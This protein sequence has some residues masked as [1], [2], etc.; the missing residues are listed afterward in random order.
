MPSARWN[1]I[2]HG[3]AQNAQVPQLFSQQ[4]RRTPDALCLSSETTSLTYYQLEKWTNGLATDLQSLGVGPETL[5][6]I[7][8]PRSP[9]TIVAALAVMKAGG[10]Y[11]PLDS[12]YPVARLHS[13]LQDVPIRV[14]IT[15]RQVGSTL[16]SGDW[17]VLFLEG[18]PTDLQRAGQPFEPVAVRSE[19]LAYA[20]YTSGSTGRPKAVQITHGGLL[21][22]V[23]WHQ[24]NFSVTPSDRASQVASFGFD[25]AAWEVWPYL[26]AGASVHFPDDSTRG[27][28]RALCEWLQKRRVTVS[29]V[30]TALAESM[31]ELDWPPTIALRLLLTGGDAL[32]KYP[33][34]NLP[35]RLVNNYGPTECTV[36][37]TSGVISSDDRQD[38][39][40]TIGRPIDNVQTYIC[41]DQLEQVPVGM[42]GELY[43]GG[44]GV[45]RGYLNNPKLNEESFVPNPF[46]NLHGDRLYKTG[47][48][49]RYLPNGEIAF[50][51]R[52]DEQIKIRGYRIEPNEIVSILNQCPGVQSS[53]VVAAG[54]PHGDKRL[55]AYLVAFEGQVTRSLLQDYLRTYLPDYMVPTTFVRLDSFPLKPT[56]KLDGFALPVP[57]P[58]NTIGDNIYVA[59]R[60]QVEQRMVSILAE[61]LGME[62][63]GVNDN[64][65]F[66][67]GHSLLGTQLIARARDS[68]GVELPLRKVFDC[69]TA[70]E[71]AAEIEQMLVANRIS[72]D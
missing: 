36:V 32:R 56:G 8:L 13:M 29:F 52:R 69:P 7:C 46:S 15:Q 49:V 28:G 5:V 64:F 20:I 57:T 39:Q 53:M 66:L 12:E 43:I 17:Q 60:N 44:A 23:R 59:P 31:I 6:A 70:A 58:L 61:L 48:L 54:D 11:V 25:A 18:E 41:N 71:L 37:T 24:R 22:L 51:G 4:A 10:A 38:R 62:K 40:P 65:F 34:A 42:V 1:D 47:D 26:C 63:V 30:P 67:G 45:S 2:S 21:N 9:G 72:A 27:S 19:N 3:Y 35:F 33:P 68:F 55:V 14:L 16:P 50:V